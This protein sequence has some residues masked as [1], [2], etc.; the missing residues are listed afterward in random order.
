MENEEKDYN[1]KRFSQTALYQS[2]NGS[3]QI[4][5]RLILFVICLFI[6]NSIMCYNIH[7]ILLEKK[8]KHKMEYS[9]ELIF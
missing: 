4:I 5:P 1:N 7:K 2:K 3:F 6:S 8:I 9:K